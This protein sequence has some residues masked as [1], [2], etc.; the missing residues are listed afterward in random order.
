MAFVKKCG[1]GHD[2][3]MENI[4]INIKYIVSIIN[5]IILLKY[6]KRKHY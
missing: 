5:I 1:H 2:K 3:E 6:P 4:Y